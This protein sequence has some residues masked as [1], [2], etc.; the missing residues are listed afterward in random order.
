MISPI[1]F[2]TWQ[3]ISQKDRSSL[4]DNCTIS[5]FTHQST[6][7][8]HCPDWW[9]RPLKRTEKTTLQFPTNFTQTMLL[10]RTLQPWRQSSVKRPWLKKIILTFSS[11]RDLRKNSFLKVNTSREDCM[12]RLT[13]PGSFCQFILKKACQRFHQISLRST[14]RRDWTRMKMR[15]RRSEN[16]LLQFII[17]DLIANLSKLMQM[18]RKSKENKKSL[19]LDRSL[20]SH[21]IAI[22]LKVISL[23]LELNIDGAAGLGLKIGSLLRV[24]HNLFDL[25]HL[26]IRP[27][28]QWVHFAKHWILVYLESS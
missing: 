14:T 7:C 11:W 28:Y 2:L 9:R 20:P 18:D 4:I 21:I 8:P 6:F 5:K 26:I 24:I 25:L 22:L 3:V 27:R 15:K 1:Q 16:D 19:S 12:I 10:P 13:W 23:G 17:C